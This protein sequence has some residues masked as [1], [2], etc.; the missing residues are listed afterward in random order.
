M[1]FLGRSP[2]LIFV[3]KRSF[4][5]FGIHV[6]GAIGRIGLFEEAFDL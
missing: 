5:L 3:A 1:S 4:V 6:N 2:H